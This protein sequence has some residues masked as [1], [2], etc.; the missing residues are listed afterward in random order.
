MLNNNEIDINSDNDSE[1]E[2]DD[3]FNNNI[4][5]QITTKGVYTTYLEYLKDDNLLL[6]PEYQR[7]ICWSIDKMILFIDTIMK[8]WIVPNYVIYELTSKESKDNDH[9]YECIDGQHRLTA[10]K[11]F[12]ESKEIPLSMKKYV[13]YMNITED[14]IKEKIFYN[15]SK[16]KLN[17]LQKKQKKYII[18]NFTKEEKNKF[19]KYQMS[20]HIISARKGITLQ[21]KCKIFNRLQNG[22]KVA[23]YEKLKNHPTNNIT[24]IIRS[25]KLLKWMN[26]IEFNNIID[27]KNIKNESFNIYFLIR[28]FLI[29]DKQSLNVNFL[30]LNI[31]KYIESVD[32]ND[33]GTPHVQLKNSIKYLLPKVKEIIEY[34]T[35][36]IEDKIIPE[37]AYIFICIYANYNI[38]ILSKI[39]KNI[40]TKYNE[41]D[42]YRLN[43]KVTTI[44][45][46]TKIY[47]KLC[48][49]HKLLE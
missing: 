39:I 49:D 24:N 42:T 9:S 15:L 16:D 32:N 31:K 11:W 13:Y 7:D 26:D 37:L 3:E 47:N 2:S 28:S 36:K 22:E 34:L 14:G 40:D 41:L 6:K 10:I 44:E 43:N 27:T 25:E 33:Q 4:Q 35:E 19:D 29:I 30:D 46:I 5:T 18:R 12:I 1:I 17:E 23:S 48:K 8:S 20:F 38:K 45:K 21:T